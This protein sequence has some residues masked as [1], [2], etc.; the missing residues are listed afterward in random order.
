MCVVGTLTVQMHQRPLVL[1][2]QKVSCLVK[3]DCSPLPAHLEK[4]FTDT[5]V[6]DDLNERNPK[7]TCTVE[8]LITTE[9]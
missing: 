7:T 2:G 4:L 1:F 6:L 3:N 9:T 5:L 8:F